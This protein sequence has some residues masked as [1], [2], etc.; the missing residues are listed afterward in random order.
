M[1][2]VAGEAGEGEVTLAEEAGSAAA[3]VELAGP[4]GEDCLG[5]G[6]VFSGLAGVL[7]SLGLLLSASRHAF[8]LSLDLI[9]SIEMARRKRSSDS[10]AVI[11]VLRG[12][13][14]VLGGGQG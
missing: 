5:P 1:E 11:F 10:S 6:L 13:S 4:D 8:K 2:L 3:E 12:L 9:K 14:F 7:L